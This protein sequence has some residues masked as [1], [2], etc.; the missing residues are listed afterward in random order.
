MDSETSQNLVLRVDVTEQAEGLALMNA[1]RLW[2]NSST[3]VE[4]SRRDDLL[5]DKQKALDS[6][7]SFVKKHPAEVRPSDIQAWQAE[8][9]GKGLRASTIYARI[10]FL[11][12]FY[13]W[14]MRDP[15]LDQHIGK[16]PVHQARPCAPK[17]YQTESVKSLTDEELDKLV[18]VVAKKAE[19][20]ELVGKR[21]YA[22]LLLFMA[23]GMRRQE[24]LSLRGKDVKTDDTLVLTNRIK[25]GTYVGREVDD[26]QVKD[27][28][29]DYLRSAKRLEVFRTDGPLWTRHD[30]AGRP[31]AA[32]SSH[33]Y[34]KNLKRYAKDAGIE[35]FHM[36]QTRHTFA[37]IVAEETGSIIETQDALNHSN[38]S[39]TRIYVQ[40]IAVKKDR[41][42]R[43]VSK[44]FS[45]IKE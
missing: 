43:L 44:R 10:C 29:L 35:K 28:L 41:H 3:L 31:G 37:R 20:G 22:I 16:N 2:A 36:H 34:V 5:R 19:T 38:P 4:S 8:L 26:P 23:T 9:G 27:A 42:S 12:S 30:K 45:R 7:F 32:L 6:F 15:E 33:S 11:S 17:A 39:T 25:G 13:E 18:S 40:R 1:I 24:V 21:D 14:A